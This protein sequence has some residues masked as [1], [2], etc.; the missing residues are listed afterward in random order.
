MT[1]ILSRSLPSL[2]KDG[3]VSDQVIKKMVSKNLV[4]GLNLLSST[5]RICDACFKGKMTASH[6]PSRNSRRGEPGEYIVSDICFMSGTS[7]DSFTM[8]VVFK[9]EKS[10]YRG[11]EQ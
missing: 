4:T 9:G 11:V 10:G 8:F 7:W 3:L 1:S 5:R 2:S 6:H